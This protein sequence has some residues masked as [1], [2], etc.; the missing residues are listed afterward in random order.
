MIA[1]DYYRLDETRFTP[2]EG[3]ALEAEI[4]RSAAA[5][6]SYELMLLNENTLNYTKSLKSGKHVINATIGTAYQNTSQDAKT[7]VYINAPSDLFS[8]ISSIGSGGGSNPQT[9]P[10]IDSVGSFSPSWKLMSFFAT[11]H[12]TLNGKYIF[13][14]NIR[15]DGSSRFA[16]NNRWGYFPSVSAAW[17]ISKEAF[18]ESSK[19]VNDLK[20]RASFGISGNQEVG[21][22][23][24]FNALVSAPYN[25][26]S[27]IRI[28][29]LGNRDFQWEDTKQYNIGLDAGFF[30]GR[31]GL[32]VDAYLKETSHLFNHIKLPG[33]SGFDSYAVSEGSVRNKGVELNIYGKILNTAFG[34]ETNL[35]AAYNKNEIG[36][37]PDKLDAVVNYGNYAAIVQGGASIGAFYG[38]NALGVYSGNSDVKVKNGINDVNPFK[39]GDVIFEDV[40]NNGVIDENDRK[41]IGNVNPDFFGG[42]SNI[43]SYK[44]FDLT[45][46]MDFAVGNKVFNAHRALLE[47]MSN[48]D[49]QSAAINSRWRKEGDITDMPRLLHGD[50]VGNTRFS[51]RWV[52]DGSYARFKAIT[53]G[54]NFPVKGIFKDAFKTARVLLTAQNLYTFTHYKG[55]SPEVS[56]VANPLMYGVDNGNV[57]QL[58]AFLLGVKLGL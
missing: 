10:N 3:F 24:A 12:Y 56:N 20:L 55:Y 23:N 4:I 41:I 57:P 30:S 43:F 7:A 17:H 54:Y 29:I 13:A 11:A 47:S 46:F 37:L 58:R 32:S 36:T 53:V 45:V 34:W 42:F 22:F 48:Y 18:L 44:G 6:K 9:D 39:G 8:G 15:T 16:G 25:R 52:E 50:A 2:S 33:I 31:V 21:Y 1:A 26:V 38:Y 14:G 51:S 19:L 27:G 28:G 35:T 5:A 40:D 49:N